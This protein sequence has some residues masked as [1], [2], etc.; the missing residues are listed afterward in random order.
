MLLINSKGTAVHPFPC[1]LC[2]IKKTV[3]KDNNPVEVWAVAAGSEANFILAQY[4]ELVP[5]KMEI[6]RMLQQFRENPSEDF[7]FAK[8]PYEDLP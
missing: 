5:A 2:F 7:I 3:I 4:R 8:D 1:P 6:Q